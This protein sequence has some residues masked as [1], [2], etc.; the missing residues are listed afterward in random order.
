L[1]RQATENSFTSFPFLHSVVFMKFCMP[2]WFRWS[3]GLLLN[4]HLF[5]TN[6]FLSFVYPEGPPTQ[7]NPLLLGTGI[8]PFFFPRQ[9]KSCLLPFFQFRS[10]PRLCSLFRGSRSNRESS[11]D[12][13]TVVTGYPEPPPQQSQ[14]GV[15]KPLGCSP[16]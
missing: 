3:Q 7:P 2:G 16:L 6:G 4:T 8:G 10:T 5:V 9:V 14:L 12:R 15:R 1:V 13:M 11:P